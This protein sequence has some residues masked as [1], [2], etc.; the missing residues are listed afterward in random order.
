MPAIEPPL[1]A[2]MAARS[3]NTSLSIHCDD[4]NN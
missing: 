2:G 1:V 3:Y 4:L